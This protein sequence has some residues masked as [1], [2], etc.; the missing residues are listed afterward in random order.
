MNAVKDL[1]EQAQLA[2]AAYAKFWNAATNS[3]ITD[4][5]LV[6]NA[7]QDTANNGSFSATQAAEFVNNWRVVD[8]VPDLNS[9]FSATIFESLDNP[10]EYSLAIRG[11]LLDDLAVDF[12]ADVA[13]IAYEGVATEQLID[14]Y[15]F[16]QRASTPTGQTYEAATSEKGSEPFFRVM[17]RTPSM[18]MPDLL[19]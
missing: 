2:E 3:P 9:G 12:R 18:I 8:H 17:F 11:S 6:K 19:V 15:N 4:P 16:W 10:G 5:T 7:L 13:L 1:F 14:L